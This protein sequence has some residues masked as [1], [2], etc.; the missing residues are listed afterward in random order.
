MCLMAADDL[1]VGVMGGGC[2]SPCPSGGGNFPHA[3]A[4]LGCQ[5]ED[6]VPVHVLASKVLISGHAP[7]AASL[8]M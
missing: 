1:P 3:L 7:C 6:A 4:D 2:C 8:D 5:P